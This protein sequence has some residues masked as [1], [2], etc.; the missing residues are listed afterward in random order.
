MKPVNPVFQSNPTNPVNKSQALKGFLQSGIKPG[1]TVLIHSALRPFGFV[2]G[3][4]RTIAD[5]L[6]EVVGPDGTVVAPAFTFIHET[7]ECPVID[8]MN[9][10]SEM[11]AI[12]EAIRKLPGALR[13]AAYRHSF[14]A[15]GPNAAA[16]TEVD[17]ALSVFD[18]RSSFG[19]MLALDTRIVMAGLTYVSCTSH[20]FGEYIVKVPCRHTVER[21]VRLR[22]TDGTLEEMVMMDYQPK[23]NSTGSYYEHPHDFDKIGKMLEEASLVTIGAIGNAVIRTFKMRDLIHFIIDSY[24]LHQD[25]FFQDEGSEEPT[26]LY[27]GVSVSTGDLLDGAGRLVETFWS[28]ID[29]GLMYV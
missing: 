5:A 26:R 28:C 12:S 13:S 22:R 15:I 2:E 10:K 6:L 7:E 27:F 20:H 8:P 19:K 24:P 9:D 1:E 17:P 18:M 25:L 29:P 4:A 23:P 16:I 21:K 14:S 11:G 3:G